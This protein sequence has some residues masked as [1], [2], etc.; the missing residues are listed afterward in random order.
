MDT[1]CD[2]W[3][4]TA[5]MIFLIDWK[6]PLLFIWENKP[7]TN[8]FTDERMK[9]IIQQVDLILNAV[10]LKPLSSQCL[11][12]YNDLAQSAR[13]RWPPDQ[14]SPGKTAGLEWRQD[15]IRAAGSLA[16]KNIGP[17]TNWK[18]AGWNSRVG[19]GE[20]S[21]DVPWGRHLTLI[22][23]SADRSALLN[24]ENCKCKKQSIVGL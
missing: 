21:G 10:W 15:V 23:V 2:R 13:V 7:E 1:K 9:C 22:K 24:G 3:V 4:V 11:F 17:V 14:L 18:V 12:T 5:N 6:L 8:Q 16:I 20:K 19:R